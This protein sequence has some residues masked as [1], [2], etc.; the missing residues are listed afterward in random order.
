MLHCS[1]GGV[2][3]SW[4]VTACGSCVDD[5]ADEGKGVVRGALWGPGSAATLLAV[6]ERCHPWHTGAAPMPGGTAAG[7]P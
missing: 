1:R 6:G 3:F 4:C 7:S 2:C 5:R